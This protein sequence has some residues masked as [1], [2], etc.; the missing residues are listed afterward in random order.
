M[1]VITL[2][3]RTARLAGTIQRAIGEA[4]RVR[5]EAQACDGAVDLRLHSCLAG[6]LARDLGAPSQRALEL[7]RELAEARA[8]GAAAQA[9][10]DSLRAQLETAEAEYGFLDGLRNKAEAERDEAHRDLATVRTVAEAHEA[11]VQQLRAELAE[12]RATIARQREALQAAREQADRERAELAAQLVEARGAVAAVMAERDQA[13]ADLRE[14][15][16]LAS[17]ALV[18]RDQLEALVSGAWEEA[19]EA[20]QVRA[21]AARAGEV[22]RAALESALDEGLL[23]DA[24]AE[25]AEPAAPAPAGTLAQVEEIARQVQARERGPATWEEGPADLVL[26]ATVAQRRAVRRRVPS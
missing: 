7:E 16:D 24:D 1:T 26:R 12:A 14:Q 23:D 25:S 10:A 13:R 19:A 9:A 11:E 18:E 2:D 6:Q 3:V 17:V 22:L 5:A 8:Q 15:R 20:D 21:V 4:A